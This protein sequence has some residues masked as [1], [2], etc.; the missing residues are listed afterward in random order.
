MHSVKHLLEFSEKRFLKRLS[1]F[2][3]FYSELGICR[4]YTFGIQQEST[5]DRVPTSTGKI[6]KRGWG[7]GGVRR[8][9]AS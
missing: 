6:R 7:V 3:S 8:K 5:L 9:E 1:F 4:K 2:H